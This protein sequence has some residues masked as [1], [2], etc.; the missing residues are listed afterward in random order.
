MP[1]IELAAPSPRGKLSKL[2]HALG[3]SNGSSN[4]LASSSNSDVPDADLTLRPTTSDGVTG[5]LRDRL[6]RKSVDDRRDSQDSGKRE[7]LSNL[8]ARQKSKAKNAL[9]SDSDRQLTVDSSSNGNLGIAGNLS[10]SSLDLA[11]SGRSSL[12]TDG[13][14]EHEG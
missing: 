5:K 8:I 9:S 1:S 13:E 10:G 7:R 14:S 3:D 11:G 6:R 4:S 12:L 2:K